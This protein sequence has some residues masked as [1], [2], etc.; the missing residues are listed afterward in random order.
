MIRT[1][2]KLRRSEEVG[3]DGS[4]NNVDKS[5]QRIQI[6]LGRLD[7]FQRRSRGNKIRN[8]SHWQV[9]Q[10]H[11]ASAAS[12]HAITNL[13]PELSEGIA[14]LP[15]EPTQVNRRWVGTGCL[16]EEDVVACCL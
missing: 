15:L 9:A 16:L 13:V 6:I 11:T 3:A 7:P 8:R 5:L 2:Y 10:T 1:K 14:S 12:V 4:L